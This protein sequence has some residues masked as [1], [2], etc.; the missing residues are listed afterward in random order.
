MID[1]VQGQSSVH[2]L[3][4]LGKRLRTYVPAS[5]KLGRMYMITRSSAGSCIIAA[6]ACTAVDLPANHDAATPNMPAVTPTVQAILQVDD[7][8]LD[9]SRTSLESLIYL[10]LLCLQ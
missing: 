10:D 1:H 9:M 6:S 4:G 7:G 2:D 3:D 8:Q 5:V